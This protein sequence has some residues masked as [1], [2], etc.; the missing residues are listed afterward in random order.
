MYC[1]S[2][3]EIAEA[4]IV[5]LKKK[6]SSRCFFLNMVLTN[7]WETITPWS[8]LALV[9]SSLCKVSMKA[10]EIIRNFHPLHSSSIAGPLHQTQADVCSGNPHRWLTV[11]L[12][13]ILYTMKNNLF[14]AHCNKGLT[15]EFCTKSPNNHAI[16]VK[17]SLTRKYTFTITESW[18]SKKQGGNRKNCIWR[19]FGRSVTFRQLADFSIVFWVSQWNLKRA[20]N[21]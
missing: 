18:Q 8:P 1:D 19:C 7:K 17:L 12:L 21:T 9:I 11:K 14:C 4:I 2:L 3:K 6:K 20:H 10:T 5:K 15:V 13:C 16:F